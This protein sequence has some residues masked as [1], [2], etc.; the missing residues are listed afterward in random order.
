[1]YTCDGLGAG[2]ESVYPSTTSCAGSNYIVYGVYMFSF[3]V[4]VHTTDC[5]CLYI[6]TGVVL[7]F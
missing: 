6:L 2:S 3:L 5:L 7:L 1:M 4:T